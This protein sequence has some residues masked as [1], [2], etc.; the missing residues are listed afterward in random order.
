MYIGMYVG[1]YM[2]ASLCMYMIFCKV[3][4]N[5]KISFLFLTFIVNTKILCMCV[6]VYSMH[7]MHVYVCEYMCVYV[8]MCV[9]IRMCVC[10]WCM[11]KNNNF[12]FAEFSGSEIFRLL[13]QAVMNVY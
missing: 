2:Y 5:F 7:R 9:S 6:C 11:C 10:V 8:C 13:I 3:V 12:L 4:I 1:M